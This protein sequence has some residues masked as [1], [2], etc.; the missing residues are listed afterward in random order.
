MTAAGM[1]NI[2]D[3]EQEDI[4]TCRLRLRIS[5]VDL[6][7]VEGHRQAWALF[8]DLWERSMTYLALPTPRA[9]RMRDKLFMKELAVAF[10]DNDQLNENKG[11][12][13][14]PLAKMAH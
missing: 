12:Y 9:A 4:G 11:T 10:G 5:L 1:M 6:S 8:G 13:L 14:A 7:Q 2:I 3:A